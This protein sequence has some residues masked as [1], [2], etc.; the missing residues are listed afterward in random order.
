MTELRADADG[1]I[2][3][4]Y[5]EGGPERVHVDFGAGRVALVAVDVGDRLRQHQGQEDA[6]GDRAWT[7]DHLAGLMGVPGGLATLDAAGLVPAAQ[8]PA[9]AQAA[10]TQLVAELDQERGPVLFE[11]TA[12]LA[13]GSS[14]RAVLRLDAAAEAG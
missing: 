1:M 11:G 13:D 7:A 8:L 12:T 3:R 5:V 14:V 9:T 10:E 2:P 4:F 6:H